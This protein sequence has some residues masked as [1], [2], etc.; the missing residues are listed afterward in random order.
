LGF[1]G[2]CWAG[3]CWAG[4]LLCWAGLGLGAAGWGGAGVRCT[5]LGMA[6]HD[7]GS[8]VGRGI[9]WPGLASKAGRSRVRWDW[10]CLGMAGRGGIM[11]EILWSACCQGK[12]LRCIIVGFKLNGSMS[13][14]LILSYLKGRTGA[15]LVDSAQN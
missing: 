2:P 6:G 3:L 9:V 10:G 7:V 12:W 4:A 15:F 8:V 5:G 1:V 11:V 13:V 14:K